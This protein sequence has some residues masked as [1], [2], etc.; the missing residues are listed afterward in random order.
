MGPA[1]QEH[2]NSLAK[3][4]ALPER[5]L[6]KGTKRMRRSYPEKPLM[7]QNQ[8]RWKGEATNPLRVPALLKGSPPARSPNRA[9][10]KILLFRL[11]AP[12]LTYCLLKT[13][14][15]RSSNIGHM[16]SWAQW[17]GRRDR[18]QEALS[19]PPAHPRQTCRTSSTSLSRFGAPRDSRRPTS[20]LCN[21]LQWGL[22]AGFPAQACIRW[23]LRRRRTLQSSRPQCSSPRSD[24]L[25]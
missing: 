20:A 13:V 11:Q 15:F 18:A 8:R 9:Q 16:R 19:W 3:H 14:S 1:Y 21:N 6:P 25:L 22:G 12:S 23:T 10:P 4:E 2:E 24:S 5:Q 7:S 17:Q